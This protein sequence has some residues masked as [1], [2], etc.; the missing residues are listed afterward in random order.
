MPLKKMNNKAKKLKNKP[1][2]SK[3]ILNKIKIRNNI[4]AR[5]KKDPHN[6]YLKSAYN[7]FR[8][9]V[10]N[11]IKVSKKEYYDAYFQNCKNNMRKTWAGIN[12]LIRSSHRSTHI[13]QIQH[14]NET[15][16]EPKLMADAFNNF[17]TSA[18]PNTDDEILK[19]PISP[20]TF[21]KSRVVNNLFAK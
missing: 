19:T 9:S 16:T 18:G 15:I 8:N 11:D 12:D 21:L 5:K 10:N 13:N 14:N 3:K 6:V 1:W 7:R 2:I 20:L 4:F 17:F